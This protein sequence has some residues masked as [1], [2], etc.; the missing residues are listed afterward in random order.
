MA[1]AEDSDGEGA[2]DNNF[3]RDSGIAA[4]ECSP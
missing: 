3:G 4:R 2:A 1:D